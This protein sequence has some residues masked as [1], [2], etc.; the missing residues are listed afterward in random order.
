VD[1]DFEKLEEL[2]EWAA[3]G[4]LQSIRN[5]DPWPIPYGKAYR[6]MYEHMEVAVPESACIVPVEPMYDSCTYIQHQQWTASGMILDFNHSVGLRIN[7]Y[8]ADQKSAERPE[9]ADFI[10]QLLGELRKHITH[11][12]GYTHS[13]PDIR[14]VVGEGFLAMEAELDNE[15][16]QQDCN[17]EE[18]FF[19]Q[20]LKHYSIGV[21]AFYSNTLKALDDALCHA[22][23]ERKET[24]VLIRDAFANC[25]MKP[26]RT[27]LEGLLAINFTWM[28][29]GCDSIGRVDQVLGHLLVY[30][31]EHGRIELD[32]A[33]RLIDEWF[34]LFNELNGW[35]MQIGGYTPSGDDGCNLLTE[36]I[37]L[38]CKRNKMIRPNVAFRITTQTPQRFMNL[39]LDA[40][41]EGAGRPALYNDDLYV[42]TLYG[43][44]LGI[45]RE[46]SREIGFGGCT[47]TMIAGMSNVGSLEFTINLAQALQLALDDEQGTDSFEQFIELV[48]LKIKQLTHDA[49]RANQ[50]L[51]KQRFH[52]GDPKLYRSFFTRDCVKNRRSFE[53]GGARYN[54][55][56]VSYEGVANLI[57]SLAAAKM[58]VYDEKRIGFNELLKALKQDFKGFESLQKQL[59]NAPKFGND[60]DYVDSIGNKIMTFTWRE[61]LKYKTPRGGLYIPSVILFATYGAAGKHIG[62]TPDGR[63]AGEVLADSV[64]AVQGKDIHGPTALMNSV[65]KLPLQLAIGTPVLN[66]R[67]QKKMLANDES[68]AKMAKLVR[69]Y[70]NNGGLQLQVSVVS[71]EAMKEAQKT[72]E[73]HQDLIVRIGGYSEYFNKLPENLQNSVIAR[74][75]Y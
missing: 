54:F 68:I 75:E 47:E 15:L 22:S 63:Y 29:D 45:S 58:F 1:I 49:V 42:E 72:P 33:R 59:L 65:T 67:M 2:K 46:D 55:T 7:Q 18:R 5:N 73:K 27:F 74:T 43:M 44:D 50:D 25:F 36:E 56:I 23:A 57:D 53:A 30:D 21:N 51:L 34:L 8:V 11:L 14:R 70:F 4:F 6:C 38:A 16:E 41:A 28:L 32:F 24:L 13:N 26:A 9:Y 35:N 20:A 60:I 19:L 3:L 10:E 69:S 17:N 31:L 52:S 71:T 62:A 39:A 64:G 61:L 12:G 48:K 40:L 66:I 37:L